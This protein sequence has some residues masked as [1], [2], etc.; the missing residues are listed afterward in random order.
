MWVVRGDEVKA[1]VFDLLLC[2]HCAILFTLSDL[3]SV[4]RI[5]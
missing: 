3:G 4:L 1:L 2:C 5:L